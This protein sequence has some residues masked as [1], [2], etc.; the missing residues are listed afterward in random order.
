MVARSHN[1]I[2][3]G[4]Y[5]AY[6]EQSCKTETESET[7]NPCRTKTNLIRPGLT[8]LNGGKHHSYSGLLG[9]FTVIS[10]SNQT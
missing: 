8:T 5:N 7:D 4:K 6:T 10:E 1:S 2:K 3:D 9:V